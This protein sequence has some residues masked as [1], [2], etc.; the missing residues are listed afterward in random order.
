MLSVP[1]R[2]GARP[3]QM[4]RVAL[5]A[6][7]ALSIRKW[8]GY[9]TT[10]A[11]LEAWFLLGVTR[12]AV[13]GFVASIVRRLR[14]GKPLHEAWSFSTEVSFGVMREATRW[15]QDELW[16]DH[17]KYVAVTNLMR[18]L[19]T[20][21]H[22]VVRALPWF[23]H[24]RWSVPV[25][26]RRVPC[27]VWFH[28]RTDPETEAAL[29][30][31]LEPGSTAV[32][33]SNVVFLVYLHGGGLVAGSIESS[34]PQMLQLLR[35]TGLREKGLVPVVVLVDFALGPLM[36]YPAAV[37]DTIS[38]IRHLAVT[39]DGKSQLFLLGDS[40]GGGLVAASVLGLVEDSF[41]PELKRE[42]AVMLREQ[43]AHDEDSQ[44]HDRLPVAG[45]AML[46]PQLDQ[47]YI[48]K[49]FT[50][51]SDEFD[52]INSKLAHGTARA[53]AHHCSEH[54][55]ASPILANDELLKCFP[56]C[57][58][59][60]GGLE[61]FRKDIHD[62]GKRLT[63]Q[64]VRVVDACIEHQVHCFPILNPSSKESMD[65]MQLMGDFVIEVRAGRGAP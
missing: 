45:C 53:Y 44:H 40:G 20:P 12:A 59:M 32:V 22:A 64:G 21:V 25:F 61:I 23:R 5:A 51:G 31:A 39:C 37:L 52:I 47:R 49:E 3:S 42:L 11:E 62:F 9:A 2:K 65:I 54:P 1:P 56:P 26:G 34:V 24:I 8:M 35:Q 19:G 18:K 7:A 27:E 10:M 6:V 63:A 30:A 28:A 38:V 14:R 13:F 33:P 41:F 29:R 55:T 17:R 60:S 48:E 36:P 46:S 16:D 50:P 15:A 4:R 43:R 58:F 57:L